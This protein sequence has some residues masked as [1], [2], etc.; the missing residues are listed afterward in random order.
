MNVFLAVLCV[1]LVIVALEYLDKLGRE[2][3]K[4]NAMLLREKL[5]RAMTVAR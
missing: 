1:V 2:R 3:S 4:H 5:Y